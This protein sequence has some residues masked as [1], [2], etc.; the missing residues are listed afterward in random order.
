MFPATRE[1]RCWW[2]KQ[3]NILAALPK[4]AH[5]AADAAMREIY[6][7]DDIDKAQIAIKAFEIDNGANTRRRSPRSSTT[8]TCYWSS[9]G[10]PPNI[11]STFAPL[12]RSKVLLPRYV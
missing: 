12:T 6:N 9:T 11:G 1:Q 3:A 2:H 10:I 8:P 5:P 7:A 4:S